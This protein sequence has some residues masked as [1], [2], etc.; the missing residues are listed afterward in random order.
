MDGKTATIIQLC[1]EMRQLGLTGTS[2]F[3]NSLLKFCVMK[4]DVDL[5]WNFFNELASTCTPTRH[6]FSILLDLTRQQ[7]DLSGTLLVLD[8]MD[9]TGILPDRAMTST[10]MLTLC[11]QHLYTDAADLVDRLAQQCPQLVG[12]IY[13][14]I[15]M[16]TLYRHYCQH[17][18]H[19]GR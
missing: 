3:Y 12:P 4:Q 6:T 19:T 10:V 18:P 15:L 1:Q 7:K 8:R 5:A 16:D 13:R 9:Q 2:T 17:G 11:D 14:S